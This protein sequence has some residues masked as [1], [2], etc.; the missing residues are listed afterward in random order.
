MPSSEKHKQP[1]NRSQGSGFSTDVA[2]KTALVPSTQEDTVLESRRTTD[3]GLADIPSELAILPLRNVVVY[4]L[5]A[6][7]LTVGRPRSIRLIDDAVLG[8]RVIGLVAAKNPE[9]DDPGP[10]DVYKVGTAAVVH[11][12]RKAPDGTVV[13]L[14]QGLERINIHEFTQLEPYLTARVEVIPDLVEDTVEVE[15][16]MRNIVELFRRLVALVPHIPDELIM[17]ALNVDDPRQL[18]YAIATYMRMDLDDAQQI[19]EINEVTGKLRKLTV[20]LNRELEVL[21][22]GKKIQTEAQT[23][24]TKVQ[25]EYFLREQLKAIKKE[26]GEE[27]EQATEVEELRQKIEAAGMPEEAEKEAKRELDRLSKLPTAAAEYSVI[28]TYLDWLVNLPWNKSTEDNLDIARAHQV[29][30]EDHYDLE[31]IKERILEYLAVRK[32]RLERK[33]E[34]EEEEIT[35]YIRMEREGVILCFIGPPGTGKT[36]LGRSIARALGRKFVRQSLGGVR[37]EAEIRGHRR[38]YIGALPGRIIQALRRVESRNPVFMLDEIDKVGQDW[39]GDPSSALL[40]VLDPEQNRD[41]RDHYLDVPFDLS[42]VMFITTGNILDTIPPALRDRME[43]LR[44]SGYTEEEK[45]KIAQQYLIPRQIRENS[46]LPEEIEFSAGAIRKIIRDYTREA[47]VRN[48]ERELG[49]ICRKVATRVAE[50]SESVNERIGESVN[51]RI[52]ES[53]N[54]RIG[55]SANERIGESANERIGESANERIGERTLITEEKVAEFLG[56]PK[57]FFEAAERTEIP[58]VATGVAWTPSGGDIVF[59]EATRMPGK[60]GFTLTGQLGDVMKESAQAALSY[61]RSKARELGIDSNFFEE[62][63]IHI[64]VPAGAMPKDGP[65][66]G[67]TIATALASLLLNKPVRSDVGMTGE[68]TLRGQ[69]L[70]V[71]GIKEKVLAA[72]RVGLKTVIL[73]QRNEPDLD[74]VPEDVKKAMNFILADQVDQVFAAALADHRGESG[75]SQGEERSADAHQTEG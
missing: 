58:G 75:T 21:E 46:L 69:V 66:A 30:D 48:L 12:L 47:G 5:T 34:E 28:R 2:A 67:V 22:L 53:A 44:L 63:D 52:G 11:R 37:D 74:D 29:L 33:E 7:P 15:A 51:E 16:L 59:V 73:P 1:E 25:R 9:E 35:D 24:M 71:G 56:K 13:L 60:K 31:D 4:P 17:L 55:E 65:S 61:V 27:D 57:Y 38:T 54:E 23:E 40:E 49:S 43:I 3:E 62:S 32:L 6:L 68:I 36:S 50:A 45:I 18:A 64:H 14:V 19:L 10:D 8:R 42:Q 39:R 70:P 26:L 41:F 20:I 72:H